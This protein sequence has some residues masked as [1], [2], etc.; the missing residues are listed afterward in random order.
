MFRNFVEAGVALLLDQVGAVGD[1]L[2]NQLHYLG[3]GPV[4][5]ARR[6]VLVLAEVWAEA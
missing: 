3:F 6:I 5:V 1:D 4:G 2:L